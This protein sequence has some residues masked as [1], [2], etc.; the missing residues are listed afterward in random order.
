MAGATW[1][2]ISIGSFIVFWILVSGILSQML[3]PRIQELRKKEKELERG[4]YERSEISNDITWIELWVEIWPILLIFCG[5]LG[6]FWLPWKCLNL[7]GKGIGRRLRS[8]FSN[9]DLHGPHS[10]QVHPW[11]E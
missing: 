10:L 6:I 5:I 3:K 1:I 11:E 9:H 2:G 7:I 4:V 8:M